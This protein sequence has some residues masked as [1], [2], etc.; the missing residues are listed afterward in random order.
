ML[1]LLDSD[2]P[3][4]ATA[5]VSEDVD[6][7]IAISR[8]NYSINHIL[9]DS[10]CSEYK[11]FVSGEGNFRKEI[12]P[13]YKLHRADK[14]TPKWREALRL[15]LIESWGAIECNGYEADD[16]CGIH[17]CSD[18]STIICGI[19]K[20]LLQ[21]PGKHYQWPI[22][23]KGEIV[24]PGLYHDIDEE[25][26]WRNLF[27]QALTGDTADNIKGIHRIGPKKAEKILEAYHTEEEL[28]NAAQA[29]YVNRAWMDDDATEE[30]EI[31][32]FLKNCDLLYIWRSLGITY[33]IRRELNEAI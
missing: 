4:F 25:T 5:L 8:L 22:I 7:S 19:D 12:D 11:L 31:Q 26:G 15:H 18:G 23:R 27:T 33:S 14:P 1:A 28:Y 2:T 30:T 17:Q 20:D 13:S 29:A 16:A 3:I 10:G 9:E 6:L 32:R 24:R 21:I